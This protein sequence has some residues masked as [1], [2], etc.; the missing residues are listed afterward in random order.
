MKKTFSRFSIVAALLIV[1]SACMNISSSLTNPSGPGNDA[2]QIELSTNPSPPVVGDAEVAVLL[3]DK[4][5]MPVND[6]TVRITAGMS[7]AMNHGD[8]S[9]KADNKG[10]GKYTTRLKFTMA[11]DWNFNISVEQAGQPKFSKDIKLTV[12]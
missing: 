7:G 2:Y 11:N 9:G 10:G 5:G 3:K 8:A 12:K 6:A 1:L 4:T